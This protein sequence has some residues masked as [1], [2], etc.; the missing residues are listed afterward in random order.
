MSDTLNDLKKEATE[1][2]IVYSPNIGEATLR[3]K[4]QDKY[5]ALEAQS[6]ESTEQPAEAT[7]EVITLVKRKDAKETKSFR[8]I[9]KELERQARKTR[10]VRIVDNDPV[11]NSYTNCCTVNCS[12]EFFDLGTAV[13]PLDTPVEVPQ[14]HIDALKELDIMHSV[15]DRSNPA[16]STP[17]WR[18]RYSVSY[19]D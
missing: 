4:I 5:D 7:E 1:L 17:V 14:G 13:Y 15:P 6:V 18:K 9:A 16:T 8:A 12:N 10:V 19:E 11:H 3:K 2:G